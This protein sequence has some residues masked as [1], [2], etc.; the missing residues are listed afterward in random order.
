MPRALLGRS[1]LVGI[2]LGSIL[3]LM[4]APWSGP[5][6]QAQQQGQLYISV[7][8]AQG[9]PVTDLEAG[10]IS[11]QVDDADAKIVK[12]E[13]VSKPMKLTVMID[14][15]Q[16]TSNS[17]A[18]LRTSLK[19]FFESIPADVETSLLTTAPQPR[20]IVRPTK[21]RQQLLKG[22]DLIAPDSGA[23]LFFDAL[24][25]AGNRVD[26]DK[27]DYLPVFMMLASDIGRNSSAMDKE[28]ERLQKQVIQRAITVHFVI[29]HS[30]GERVGAVAGALQTEVGLALTKMS[31]GRYENIAANT[32]LTT[33]L[34]EFAQQITQSNLRQTHQYRVTFERQGK[35]AKGAA[36]KI[37]AGIS[38]L[39]IGVLPML[40]V[41]GHMP[42]GAP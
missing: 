2:A 19:G 3:C 39:R 37:S 29:L 17:L 33:L 14:N 18:N 21:D 35:D 8:D 28:W 38:R 30:G 5:R 23:A 13:P 9:A 12:L 24:V 26:K 7:L 42:V 11:V 34:P 1:R 16:A 22:V 20:W 6:L 32:R 10:D 31:G 36:Q 40:S 25:E 15:G 27:S 4:V 41:D